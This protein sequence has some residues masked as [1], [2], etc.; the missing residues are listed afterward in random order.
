MY[1]RTS[2]SLCHTEDWEWCQSLKRCLKYI[3]SSHARF[4]GLLLSL[5]KW[6]QNLLWFWLYFQASE[7]PKELQEL[8]LLLTLFIFL[9]HRSVLV[10][11]SRRLIVT[12]IHSQQT[13]APVLHT[14]QG[15][16]SGGRNQIT[17][18][19]YIYFKLSSEVELWKRMNL[20]NRN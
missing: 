14:G 11:H 6:K 2:G 19:I 16:E 3:A 20:S 17:W 10:C 9:G 13:P 7:L 12:M 1:L 8:G 18:A 15:C 5:D 4:S